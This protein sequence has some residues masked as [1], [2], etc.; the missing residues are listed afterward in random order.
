MSDPLAAAE[1]A[2]ATEETTLAG[3]VAAL[4][5]A[6]PGAIPAGILADVNNLAAALEPLLAALAT[7]QSQVTSDNNTVQTLLN[8]IQADLN[9]A[10][11]A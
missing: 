7:L 9:L 11:T 1:A 8:K 5:A 4:E 3:D 10:I 6:I 2:L